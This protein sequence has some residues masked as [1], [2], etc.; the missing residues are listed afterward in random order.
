VRSVAG[1]EL[2]DELGRGGMGV[3]YRARDPRLGRE[4][5]I[6]LLPAA[7]CSETARERFR[8][9]GETM[10]RLEHPHI[11]KVHDSGEEAGQLY[12]VMDLI[13]G[14]SL[15]D[16]LEQSGPL[17]V[18]R[19]AELTRKLS[20]AVAAAHRVNVIHR[21]LKPANVL[22][23]TAGEPRLLDF[24]LAKAL[25]ST[26]AEL[27]KSGQAM[28]TPGFWSPEQA[29]GDR[30]R[31]GPGTDVYGLGG[32]LYAALTGRPPIDLGSFAEIVIAT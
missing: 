22:I 15:H 9:E 24:G 12:L 16:R 27:S 13:Q 31:I 7:R 4:V 1:Y 3:V 2:L 30:S 21:D 11:V 19:A 32:L 25:D 14:Q 5:A 8:R 23:D 28:G 18:E 6:K 26:G 20:L 10:A 17:S 29:I